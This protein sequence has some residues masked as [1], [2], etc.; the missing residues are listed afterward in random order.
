[1]RS[2]LAACVLGL[3]AFTAAAGAHAAAPR[4]A[5]SMEQELQQLEIAVRCSAEGATRHHCTYKRPAPSG[6]AELTMHAV[7]SDESD[8]IYF[9]VERYLMLPSDH[10]Q[11]A[12]V[13]RRL[14]ELNWDLLVGKF[15]WNPRSGEVRLGALLHTDSN[16]DRRA[17]RSIVR[18]LDAVAVRYHAELHSL[19]TP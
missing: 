14:M 3:A 6:D 17:F 7:Y 18:S 10:P 1:M 2:R 9:Y 15:E 5:A 8:T 4:Y 11:A 13:L 12:A 16:F 19:L